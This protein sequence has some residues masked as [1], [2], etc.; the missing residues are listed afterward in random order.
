MDVLENHSELAPQLLQVPLPHVDAV[1]E[2]PAPL[3]V[4][5]AQEQARECGFPRSGM[6][7]HG[8]RLARTDLEVQ[9]FE[10]PVLVLIREPYV[11]EA[12]R[13]RSLA[14]RAAGAGG[15]ATVTSVSRSLKIR[16]EDAMAPWRMLNFSERSLMGRKNFSEYWMKATSPPRVRPGSRGFASLRTR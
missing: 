8:H 11:L 10:H 3:H 2:D 14:V 15:D 16:S 4:V 7:H 9:V 1:H 6:S 12:N 5:E 13:A